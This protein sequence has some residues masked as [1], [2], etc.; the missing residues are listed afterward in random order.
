VRAAVL[1]ETVGPDGLPD[2]FARMVAHPDA[3]KVVLVP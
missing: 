2:R 1:T 3:G